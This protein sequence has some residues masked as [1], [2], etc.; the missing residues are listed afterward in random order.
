LYPLQAT[1][2]LVSKFQ[3]F[4]DDPERGHLPVDP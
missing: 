4:F 2:V 1:W 3:K